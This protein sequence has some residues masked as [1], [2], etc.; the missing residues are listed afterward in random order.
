[1][2]VKVQISFRGTKKHVRIQR[3]PCVSCEAS[4]GEVIQ[5]HVFIKPVFW[6]TD[7]RLRNPE[8]SKTI[9]LCL[10]CR[11]ASHGVPPRLFC[12]PAL[13]ELFVTD[14]RAAV[15]REVEGF[16]LPEISTAST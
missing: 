8:L 13:F 6:P 2:N 7:V 16:E 9:D 12:L 1:M 15:R 14:P 5:E 11:M 3:R 10:K 4:G